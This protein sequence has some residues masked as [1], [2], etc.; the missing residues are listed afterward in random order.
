MSGRLLV[1]S[2]DDFGLTDG[3]CRGIL[4][5]A[6]T[7]VSVIAIGPALDRWA[8]ALSDSGLGLGFHV[9]VV[10][11]DPPILCAKELSTVV[12]RRGRLPIDWSRLVGRI[13]A[14]QVDMSE[15]EA[16]T[17][18]QLERLRS[19]GLEPDHIESHQHSQLWPSMGQMLIR[20]AQAAGIGAIRT[21][22]SVQRTPKGATI[23]ALALWLRR[24]ARSAGLVTTDRFAGLDDAGRLT[25]ERL[26]AAIG[27]LVAASWDTAE[28]NSHPGAD[29]DPDRARYRWGYRWREECAVLSSTSWRT[30]CEDAGI[31]LGTYADLVAAESARRAQSGGASLAGS[32]FEARTTGQERSGWRGGRE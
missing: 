29:P 24:S 31:R 27:R 28:L 7:S 16:E 30:R 13:L 15:L 20:V 2:A 11:E 23:N 25:R 18:A 10:G 4:S 17:L 12:D 14:G 9:A 26:D 3:I 32:N 6:V 22:D 1:V 8:G 19:L 5:T 21:P